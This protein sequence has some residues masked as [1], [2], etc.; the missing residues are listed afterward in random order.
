MEKFNTEGQYELSTI[1]RDKLLLLLRTARDEIV[2]YTR[3]SEKVEKYKRY[4]K[5]KKKRVKNNKN[6]ISGFIFTTIAIVSV[7][8][9]MIILEKINTGLFTVLIGA[10][11]LIGIFF[12]YVIFLAVS[13]KTIQ[14]NIRKC[15]ILLP[16]L[17]RNQDVALD[18]FYAVVKPYKFPRE[19]WYEYALTKMLEYVENYRASNWER[20]T[21]L[22]EEHLHRMRMEDNARQTLEK[23]ELQTECAEEGRNAARW[24]AAGIWLR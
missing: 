6:T 9:I 20:V 2:D 22:Y 5:E 23:I 12:V 24:A 11:V 14:R 16:D 10:L 15:E 3:C 4:I 17:E 1:T 18:K 21:D 13:S 7:I 8:V 19:Y